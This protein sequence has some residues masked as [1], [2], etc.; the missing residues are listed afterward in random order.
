MPTLMPY[1]DDFH[2]IP[3]LRFKAD[4]AHRIMAGGTSLRNAMPFD[5]QT[6]VIGVFSTGPIF[7]RTGDDSVSASQTDHYLPENTYYDMA[8]G[9]SRRT[10]HS[11]LAVIAA[12]GTCTVYI[13]EKE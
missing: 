10:L 7:L 2:P 8:L 1:D 4:G 6:R 12:T 9:D 11:H 3:V 5:P 13:S